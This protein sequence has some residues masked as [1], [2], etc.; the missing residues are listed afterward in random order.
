ISLV[1]L[2]CVL[3]LLAPV[4]SCRMWAKQP[5]RIITE[6]SAISVCAGDSVL[7]SYRYSDVPFKPYVQQLFSPGGVNI[8]R[9]A[10]EDHRHHHA[11]MFAVAVDGVNFWEE[12]K[13][14]GRQVHRQFAEVKADKR[15][16]IPFGGFVE[17]LD[18]MN[19]RSEELLLE[20]S[21][22]IEVCHVKDSRATLL[23]WQSSLSAPHG[24]ESVTLTGSHYFGLGLRFVE[25]MDVSGRFRNA[26]GRMG[27]VVR[28]DERLARANWCAYTAAPNGKP[29]TVA[30]LGHPGNVRDPTQWFTMT[31]PFAYLS[32]TLSLHREPLEIARDRPLVLRYAVALW[33]GTV[34]ND[35]IDRMYQR[36]VQTN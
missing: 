14:P 1:V 9:D 11:L 32:A 16:G 33:D 36:W 10:P 17:R 27:E 5:V 23:S 19:P 34:E 12:Q 31:K 30:M 2:L 28:G 4:V 13:E 35:Q 25:R 15:N 26:A 7:C 21:R 18:W 6:Q 3:G 24:R 29:V 8:L 22:T 20:E